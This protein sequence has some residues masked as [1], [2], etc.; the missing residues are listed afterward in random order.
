MGLDLSGPTNTRDTS[1]VIAEI[2]E[3]ELILTGVETGAEDAAI[4]AS[5]ARLTQTGHLT[6]G[7]DAPLS[8]NP[9][10][11]DRPGD[12]ALRSRLQDAGLP[13]GAV[14][15]PTMTRMAYLTLRGISLAR[16]LAH[17]VNPAPA[18]VEAHPGGAM[19]LRGA[20]LTAVH[21]L[22]SSLEA[23]W[24]LLSWLE[25][26]GLQGAAELPEPDDHVV[27]A[28]AAALAAWSWVRGDPSWIEPA[29]PPPHPY[30][31]VC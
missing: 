26:V 21:K 8:Y 6:V 13:S 10:G 27:A 23:R 3:D 24:A 18:I 31:Y 17:T 29:N 7:L 9:G 28:C 15:T 11:G 14:M 20:P 2:Q 19:V 12:R 1:L 22:K 4:Y 5:A 25:T 30:D 16:G